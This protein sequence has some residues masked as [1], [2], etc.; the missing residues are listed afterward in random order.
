MFATTRHEPADDLRDGATG[1]L[2]L[3][4]RERSFRELVDMHEQAPLLRPQVTAWLL[5]DDS[6]YSEGGGGLLSHQ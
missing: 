5:S 1:V 6:G 2:Q 3:L 4:L